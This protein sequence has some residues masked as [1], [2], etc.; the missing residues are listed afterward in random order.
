MVGFV[1][2]A[3]FFA[4]LAQSPKSDPEPQPVDT[5]DRKTQ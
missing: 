1:I 5:R 3:M 2:L 4:M